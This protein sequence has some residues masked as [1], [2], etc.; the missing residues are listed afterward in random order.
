MFKHCGDQMNDEEPQ[1]KPTEMLQ[2]KQRFTTEYSV[3]SDKVYGSPINSK[4]IEE[5]AYIFDYKGNL[6][7]LN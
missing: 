2:Q 5:N 1:N 6:V 7:S 4:L 3:S